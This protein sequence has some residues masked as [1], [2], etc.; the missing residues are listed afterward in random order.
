MNISTE[1]QEIRSR[2]GAATLIAVSKNQAFEKIE[3]AYLAG[4]RDFGENY[5]Q[6]LQTKAALAR[7][8]GLEGIRWHFIG[9]LQTNKIRQLVPI[10]WSIHTVDSL[11][12]AQKLSEEAQRALRET[13]EVFL[14]VNIDSEDSK[15]GVTPEEAVSL[16]G[17]IAAQPHLLLRG[18]MCIPNPESSPAE[19]FQRLRNLELQCRPSTH[20]GLSMGMSEDFETA[21]S[22]GATHVRVGQKIFGSRS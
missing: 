11:R 8:R 2:C 18:L 3:A 4:Q 19:A 6:E 9:R 1:L 12:S 20:G 5:A 14:Q 7:D 15:A 22:Y 17:Q 16:A 10:V 21:I 13:L